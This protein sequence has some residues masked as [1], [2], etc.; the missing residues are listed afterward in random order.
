M[1]LG[2]AEFGWFVGGGL[3]WWVAGE[4]WGGGSYLRRRCSWGYCG[5]GGEV[6]WFEGE[7]MVDVVEASR[8]EGESGR[9]CSGDV[10]WEC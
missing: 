4:R 9:H 1:E 8:A 6:A 2:F 10:G 7:G 3:G 5:G